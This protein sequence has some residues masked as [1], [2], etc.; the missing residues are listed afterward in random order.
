MVI[1]EVTTVSSPPP[2]GVNPATGAIAGEHY[3]YVANVPD[4]Q[5]KDQRARI[6]RAK[7]R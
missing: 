4:A 2:P 1:R 3:Y 7:L 5:A 6:L